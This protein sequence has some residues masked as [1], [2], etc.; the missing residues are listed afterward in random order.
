[1]KSILYKFAFVAVPVLLCAL[2]FNTES[3][4]VGT[5]SQTGG[6]DSTAAR[7]GKPN[8]VLILMDNFG[9][10][11]LGCYG[12][13]ILRG[14]P[15]PRIDKFA[16]EGMRLLNFNVEAQ[17]TPSRAALMT[18]RY[19]IRTGNA[20]VPIE[21]PMYGLTQWEVTMPKMLSAA[22][23]ATGM[24]G[25][26]HL[27]HTPGRFPT[28]LGFDEWYGI[29]NSSDESLWPGNPMFD[30]NSN[31]FARPEY[32]MEGHRGAPPTDVK[33]YDTNERRAIDGELTD[34]AV[35]FMTRQTKAGKP[36]FCYIPYTLVHYPVLPAAEFDGKTKNGVWADVLTE[37]DTYVGQLLD[38]ADKLGIK[39]NTIFIFTSD[40]GGD[41]T[42]QNWGFNGPWR[43]TLFTGLEG[44]LRVAFIIRWTGHVPA[45]AVN[46]EIVH[47]MDLFPTF[48]HIAGG[49]VPT[50]RII[51]GVDQ[52]DF[53]LGKKQTSNRDSF[54]V[55]VGK[56][57]FGVKWRNWKMMM[58]ELDD[59]YS[60]PKEYGVPRFYN[61]YLDP[62]EEHWQDY[63]PANFWVRW[64]MGKV[65][66]EHI[67]SLKKEPPIR[68]GT[69]DPYT[70]S[71]S[72]MNSPPVPMP[73]IPGE[74]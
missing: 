19:A 49:K 36:F 18:G 44:S 16:G 35:D 43:G 28:D 60:S 62:K 37:I 24:F 20:T 72:G 67:L 29:P 41:M 23:Y 4:T 26:W 51:D 53:F 47:E 33:L 64:P 25:K 71:T 1:M 14:A 2:A 58:K 39:D 38:T 74:D 12:G 17:C 73:E 50:D 5:Q 21:T 3:Q 13:G 11:E 52:T 63:G 66:T 55:Y 48:A 27:G 45:G 31:Q 56:E 8:I 30:P 70:P 42:T 54:V 32:V 15:T 61:L 22:G 68:P 59:V 46:N 9:W 57:I 10:G 6:P 69:P 65:L 34:K 40:N 7:G